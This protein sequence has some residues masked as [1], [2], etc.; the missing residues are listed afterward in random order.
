MKSQPS[1][2]KTATTAQRYRT[3][4]A[5]GLANDGSRFCEA[6]VLDDKER[7]SSASESSSRLSRSS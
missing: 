3:W 4:T 2:M 7:F 5:F 1:T 6:G